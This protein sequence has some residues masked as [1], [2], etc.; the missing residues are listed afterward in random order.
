MCYH[1]KVPDTALLQAS[2]F[3]QDYEII[4][5]YERYYHANAYDHHPIPTITTQEP[6]MIQPAEGPCT[7]R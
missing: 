3:A 2:Q 7:S 6:R 4:G 5:E 1:A